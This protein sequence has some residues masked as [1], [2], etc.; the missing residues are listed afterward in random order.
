MV[1]FLVGGT[2]TESVDCQ[3]PN[4]LI[5]FSIYLLVFSSC[6]RNPVAIQVPDGVSELCEISK[7]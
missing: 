1:Y 5:V 6:I 4:T 2:S 3:A 7:I